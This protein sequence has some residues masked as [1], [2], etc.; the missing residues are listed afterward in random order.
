MRQTATTVDDLRGERAK[1]RVNQQTLAKA[2][3]MPAYALSA[4]ENGDTGQTVTTEFAGRYKAA[5]KSISDARNAE[6][7]N[8]TNSKAK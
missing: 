2:L 8:L 1:A 5:L 7:R 3:G 4:V 6:R